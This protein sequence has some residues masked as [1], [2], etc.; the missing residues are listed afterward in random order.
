M[1]RGL[2]VVGRGRAGETAAAASFVDVKVTTATDLCRGDGSGVRGR[3]GAGPGTMVRVFSASVAGRPCV[4]VFGS[5]FGG[6]CFGLC[7][8]RLRAALQFT[9]MGNDDVGQGSVFGVNGHFD[10]PLE[11]FGTGDDISKYCVFGV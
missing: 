1:V 2:S 11:G 6:N 3:G 5:N 10:N 8:R 4:G 9:A 7:R